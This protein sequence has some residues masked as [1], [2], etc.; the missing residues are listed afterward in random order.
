MC[1]PNSDNETNSG[2]STPG[3]GRQ[4]YQGAPMGPSNSL[5]PGGTAMSDSEKDAFDQELSAFLDSYD[6]GVSDFT[7]NYTNE[8]YGTPLSNTGISNAFNDETPTVNTNA[9]PVPVQDGNTGKMYVGGV[10][11]DQEAYDQAVADRSAFVDLASDPTQSAE[12]EQAFISETLRSKGYDSNNLDTPEARQA[13]DNAVIDLANFESNASR[14]Q[15]AADSLTQGTQKSSQQLDLEMIMS[16]A[17]DAPPEQVMAAAQQYGQALATGK[18]TNANGF[19]QNNVNDIQ[20]FGGNINAQ[21]LGQAIASGFNSATTMDNPFGFD[22]DTPIVGGLGGNRMN[23][24]ANGNVTL[25]TQGGML[26]EAGFDIGK[27]FLAAKTGGVGG[28]AMQGLGLN[29]SV[30]FSSYND[31]MAGK[32]VQPGLEFNVN[33]VASGMLGQAITP[34]VAQGVFNQTGSIPLAQMAGI[35]SNALIN[36]GV[37]MVNPNASIPLG[38]AGKGTSQAGSATTTVQSDLGSDMNTGGGAFPDG[39]DQTD[40]NNFNLKD[41][42]IDTS[43]SNLN[44]GN[45]NTNTSS[46]DNNDNNESGNAGVLKKMGGDVNTLQ[47]QN[48]QLLNPLGDDGEMPEGVSLLNNLGN[49]FGNYLMR[50]KNREYGNATFRTASKNEVNRNKRRSGLG[51]GIIFG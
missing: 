5:A 7:D 13:Y 17:V 18:F 41:G 16:G 6:S 50:G 28:L 21:D 8:A 48:T 40:S 44:F 15:A 22:K 3:V 47:D 37:N 38:N 36:E 25:Q 32:A 49:G 46:S 24:D 9:P 10:E 11:V 2:E 42:N 19:L 45:D 43:L 20:M 51:A 23:V 35:G 4:D 1:G 30:P 29:T 31:F 26:G 14:N 33:N 34:K 27:S 39:V 12:A